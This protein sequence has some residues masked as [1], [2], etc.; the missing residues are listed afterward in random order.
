MTTSQTPHTWKYF[1]AGGVIQVELKSG[2]DLLRLG[3]LDQKLWMALAMPTRGLNCDSRTLDRLDSDHDGRIRPPELLAAI[4]WL[5][6]VLKDPG[7]C[8]VEGDCVALEDIQSEPLR[9][10][11]RM[12]LQLIGR[13][14]AWSMSVADLEDVSQ[15]LSSEP[16]NGDG[17]I[18]SSSTTDPFLQSL[19][20]SIT[21]NYAQVIG[22]SGKPGIDATIVEQFF[23]DL[24][25]RAAWLE[26][27]QHD[28]T[29]APLGLDAT[30]SAHAAYV[31]LAAKIDDYFERCRWVA[32]D[33]RAS[34]AANGSASD[35]AIMANSRLSAAAETLLDLPLAPVSAELSLPL[36]K[37]FHP[38]WQTQLETFCNA[39]VFAILG[40]IPDRLSLAQWQQ[41]QSTLA[42]Y[43]AWR[44]R[45]PQS[46]AKHWELDSAHALLNG[47]AQKSLEDLLSQDLARAPD[48]AQWDQ[49]FQAWLYRRDLGKILRN[50]INF[51]DFYRRQGALFQTGKLYIDGRCSELC[52]DVSDPARHTSMAGL[53]GAFLLY[54]ECQ[55][56]GQAPRSIVALMTAGDSDNLIVGR[57]GVFYDRE[58]QDWDARVQKIISN[59]I[60]LREA[61]WSPYKKFARLIEEQIAKRAA[62]AEL[63]NSARLSQS[64]EQLVHADKG[65]NPEPLPSNKVDVGT[66]AAMGVALGSLATFFGLVFGKFVDLGFWMPLGVLAL[67]LLI[68]CPSMLLAYL[69]L[70]N[71][72]LGPILDANGWA[73]NTVARLNVPFASAMTELRA[74]P[75]LAESLF[76]DPYAERTKPWKFY[77]FV[78]IVLIIAVAWVLGKCDHNLP[79]AWRSDKVFGWKH[80]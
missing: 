60:S 69:K 5:A 9:A 77:G 58:G 21:Q 25:A 62:A 20:T 55:R 68:S 51:S 34:E 65:K 6:T 23:A 57:N 32:F 2:E 39:S 16:F 18:E 36:T 24:A 3:S 41:I 54:C 59:P 17:I 7:I 40:F 26:E 80:P 53:S 37:P 75:L 33:P 66:I 78:A 1:R 29:L 64:A 27:W 73:I 44:Q 70:K 10:S 48:F 67:V 15:K 52:I 43:A 42:P 63:Q 31:S 71:R 14:D 22:K 12:L 56:A 76:A 4:H 47:S 19:I 11:A 38:A 8:L 61:F 72:N 35:F 30:A 50:F 28:S 74:E 46:Q 79:E 49:L 13:S 45:E